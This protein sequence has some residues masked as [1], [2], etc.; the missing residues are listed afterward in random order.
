MLFPKAHGLFGR[1]KVYHD[2]LIGNA[3]LPRARSSRRR[4]V[5]GRV[6]SSRA[7]EMYR[8]SSRASSRVFARVLARFRA[9]VVVEITAHLSL[10]S[11]ARRSRRGRRCPARAHA[12]HSLAHPRELARPSSSR[13]GRTPSAWR[14]FESS[15]PAPGR[16]RDRAR[17]PAA[18]RARAMRWTIR[19]KKMAIGKTSTMTRARDG[20][21]RRR[22]QTRRLTMTRARARARRR[23][24]RTGDGS[25]RK[26]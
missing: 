10:P 21:A 6:V 23:R 22:R 8:A 1:T 26:V 19:L 2:F 3:L 17:H 4:A 25:G 24:R 18:R 14:T 9:R 5:S 12:R 7:L 11:C 13:A 20:R 16:R 15:S